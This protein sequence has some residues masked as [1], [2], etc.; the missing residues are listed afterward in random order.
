[1]R[2]LIFFI[3]LLWLG[4][5][6]DSPTPKPTL[7]PVFTPNAGNTSQQSLPTGQQPATNAAAPITSATSPQQGAQPGATASDVKVQLSEPSTDTAQGAEAKQEDEHPCVSSSP[8]DLN[9]PT[10]LNQLQLGGGTTVFLGPQQPG[11]SCQIGKAMNLA[12]LNKEYKVFTA[13]DFT[14]EKGIVQEVRYQQCNCDSTSCR[15][16]NLGSVYL[17]SAAKI[18]G[19]FEPGPNDATE[20]QRTFTCTSGQQEDNGEDGSAELCRCKTGYTAPNYVLDEAANQCS[21]VYTAPAPQPAAQ[22]AQPAP[23][24]T[25]GP[26]QYGL[27]AGQDNCCNCTPRPGYCEG[28]TDWVRGWNDALDR[29]CNN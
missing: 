18:V 26:G 27:C 28:N 17:C 22:P 29:V 16:T 1:M 5:A 11:S 24:A 8:A 13:A 9:T 15:W 12:C 4:C 2:T 19:D 23:A 10:I 3:P 25:A 7:Q 21:S 6:S 14:G 20:C